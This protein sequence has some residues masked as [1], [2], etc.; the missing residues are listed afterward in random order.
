MD[1]LSFRKTALCLA[2]LILFLLCG[3]GGK[4]RSI[5]VSGNADLGEPCAGDLL[6]TREGYTLGYSNQKRQALW[7]SYILSKEALEAP[8]VKR[9][10]DFRRDPAVKYN[11][12][13]PG[14]YTR[15]GFDRGHLA[16]AAD[17]AYSRKVMS[18]S[19]FMSNMSPQ[20]A[21]CNRRSWLAVETQVRIWAKREGKVY[22]ITGPVFTP[23]RGKVSPGFRVAVP[24]A[25]FKA[26]LDL[27][28]PYKMIAFI[29]PNESVKFHSAK[30]FAVS[31]DEVE[32]LTGYDL[33]D[34]LNDE[35][36]DHLEAQNDFEQWGK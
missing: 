36:E 21:G 5:A 29:V 10:N 35:L 33:F 20:T 34:R 32:K 28:P 4:S 16:P 18:E 11:P 9:S 2:A 14:E 26:V 6:I 25:F 12:V 3:C 1:F 19:F 15:S 13:D 30:V 7:V 23:Y 24:G 31:V 22:I 8:Q 17:M 27:T